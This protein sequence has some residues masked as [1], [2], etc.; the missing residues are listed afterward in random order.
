MKKKKKPLKEK[1]RQ[2]T[3][4]ELANDESLQWCPYRKGEAVWSDIHGE[5]LRFYRYVKDKVQLASLQ[6]I[7]P[8]EELVSPLQIRRM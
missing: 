2:F 3:V 4:E 8:L 5:A 7:A 6:G 1:K